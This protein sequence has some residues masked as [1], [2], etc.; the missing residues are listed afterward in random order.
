MLV[1]AGAVL[2]APAAEDVARK[3]F[4]FEYRDGLIWV[5]VEVRESRAPLNFLLDSGAGLSVVN[6]STLQRIGRLRG[7]RISV[8]GVG[9]N[10]TGYW[11]Q[12]LGV[13][14]DSLPVAKDVLAVD[15][16]ELSRTCARTVD[17]LVG[18]DFFKRFVVQVDFKES[19]LRLDPVGAASTGEVS[20]PLQLHGDSLRVPISVN[21][22]PAQWVRLDTGCAGALH[23]VSAGA[24]ARSGEPHVSVGLAPL[25]VPIIR[26]S[27]QLGS[28]KFDSV[29]T[30]MHAK[31]IFAGEA[32]L[33]GNELL[34][35][36]RSVT[37]DTRVGRVVL[38][39]R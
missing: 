6:M 21:G 24:D 31:E 23:W 28:V 26:A 7:K 8:R 25:K 36:F 35:Q 9:R 3:E 33:L 4:P 30:G 27:V 13:T 12:R 29:R 38:E 18:A 39:P 19:R 1:L 37:I 11:P 14:D 16:S 2:A 17:G 15:L 5:Q 32:G 34:S 22:R 10:A 20:L